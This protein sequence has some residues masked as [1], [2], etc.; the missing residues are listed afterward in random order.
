MGLE[1]ARPVEV[2]AEVQAEAIRLKNDS[3]ALFPMKLPMTGPTRVPG[4][5]VGLGVE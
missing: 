3:L 1:R 4:A 2:M 5:I